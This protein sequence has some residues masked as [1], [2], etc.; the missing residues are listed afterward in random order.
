MQNDECKDEL[1][2]KMDL[3]IRAVALTLHLNQLP[4]FFWNKS[5]AVY[6]VVC[7]NN[8]KI[9]GALCQ[10]GGPFCTRVILLNS[11]EGFR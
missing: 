10:C 7:K 5:K 2:C 8:L 4:A 9:Q 6:L 1:Y 3:S 11:A